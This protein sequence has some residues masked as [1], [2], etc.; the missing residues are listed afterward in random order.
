MYN[1]ICNCWIPT[2]IIMDTY[3]QIPTPRYLTPRYMTSGIP[4]P[5]DSYPPEI[6]TPFQI[7]TLPGYLLPRIPTPPWYLPLIPTG[8][9]S[10]DTYHQI[11]TTQ[12]TYLWYL[13]QDTYPP[14]TYP[15]IPITRYLP[16]EYLPLRY[17][18]PRY[19]PPGIPTPHDIYPP[20]RY[21][22][23]STPQNYLSL[24]YLSPGYLLPWD[25]YSTRIP[26]PPGYLPLIRTLSRCLPPWDTYPTVD[27]M[28]DSCENITFTQLLLQ[29]VR[30]A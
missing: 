14:D 21:L 6:L 17:L 4:T 3:H 26:T 29:A 11:P 27:R 18:L 20:P 28:T 7:P 2:P 10:W 15:R 13:P 24:R 23:P 1:F 16:P 5:Q 30:I 8:Y 9:L 22:P 25:T 19:I 12:H